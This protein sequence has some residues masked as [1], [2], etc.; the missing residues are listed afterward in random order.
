MPKYFLN[1][2]NDKQS[3]QENLKGRENSA[4]A[5][6]II[7][8]NEINEIN[9]N[10]NNKVSNRIQKIS[11]TSY[12]LSDYLNDEKTPSLAYYSN[13]NLTDERNEKSLMNQFKNYI[14]IR[15]KRYKY[16]TESPKVHFYYECLFYMTFLL[17]FSYMLL[18]DFTYYNKENASDDSNDSIKPYNSSI[19]SSN[20]SN[21]EVAGPKFL[22]I[23]III[24]VFS[25]FIEEIKQVI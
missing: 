18:C 2:E 14:K 9:K 19:K 3:N 25:F 20:N 22:E 1:V 12:D 5:P 4:L 16:F 7:K 23:V 8:E 24:W 15:L 10:L 21:K 17:I 6:N 11:Q 13:Q